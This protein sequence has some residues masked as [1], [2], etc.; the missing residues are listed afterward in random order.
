MNDIHYIQQCKNEY[1]RRTTH[2][3]HSMFATKEFILLHPLA[4]FLMVVKDYKG[5]YCTARTSGQSTFLERPTEK[6]EQVPES[7]ISELEKL[8]FLVQIEFFFYLK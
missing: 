4:T 7:G 6:R 5:H 2:C 8:V 1:S 3:A